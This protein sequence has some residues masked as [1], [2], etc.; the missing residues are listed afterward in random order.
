VLSQPLV[1]AFINSSNRA[2]CFSIVSENQA[3]G[4]LPGGTLRAKCGE[5]VRNMAL[6]ETPY[7]GG[8]NNCA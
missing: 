4:I 2:S 7:N 8:G 5:I 3:N 1:A 6:L